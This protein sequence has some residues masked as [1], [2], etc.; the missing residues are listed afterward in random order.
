MSNLCR[1]CYI[2]NHELSKKEI[3]KLMSTTDKFKCDQCGE[4]K[5]IV[6]EPRKK[7]VWEEDE[8]D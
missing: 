8:E 1:R 2:N 6:V 4:Y 3:K 7:E 5:A